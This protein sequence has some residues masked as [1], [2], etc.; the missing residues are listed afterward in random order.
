MGAGQCEAGLG[1]VLSCLCVF[2]LTFAT[3]GA[4]KCTPYMHS[5]LQGKWALLRITSVLFCW[6]GC[7]V[8]VGCLE[9]SEVVHATVLYSVL[10]T[11]YV[12]C[13][14]ASMEY[15]I[16]APL[17]YYPEY[18]DS[19]VVRTFNLSTSITPR[20]ERLYL[21]CANTSAAGPSARPINDGMKPLSCDTLSL[22]C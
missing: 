11:P 22:W 17:R 16:C 1:L 14:R 7:G 6:V 4:V 2:V 12:Q 10:R 20:Y 19:A 9:E 15:S 21:L 13:E 3:Q 5:V 8:F 18:L